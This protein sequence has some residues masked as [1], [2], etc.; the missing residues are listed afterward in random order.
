MVY[1]TSSNLY[2][3]YYIMTKKEALKSTVC[4][5]IKNAW[6]LITMCFICI[7][8]SI[9]YYEFLWPIT[10]FLVAILSAITI[11]GFWK[12]KQFMKSNEQ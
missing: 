3:I 1:Y 7:P 12:Y 5:I 11:Y 4:N 2:F 9:T 8:L 10:W 6:Y